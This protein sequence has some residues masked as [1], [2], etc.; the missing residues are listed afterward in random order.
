MLLDYFGFCDIHNN[1]SL[2]KCYLHF[3]TLILII[4]NIMKTPYNNEAL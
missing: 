3:N 2:G 1:H 4:P